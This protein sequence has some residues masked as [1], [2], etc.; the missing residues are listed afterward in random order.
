[1]DHPQPAF[2]L[3]KSLSGDNPVGES[4]LVDWWV[5]SESAEK[6]DN[7]TSH[8]EIWQSMELPDALSEITNEH[9]IGVFHGEE[10]NLNAIAIGLGLENIVFDPESFAG[11]IYEIDLVDATVILF[12]NG[13]RISIGEKENT[14][15][16]SLQETEERLD[17]IGLKEGST[18]TTEDIEAKQVETLLEPESSS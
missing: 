17:Q 10:L 18:P 12:H 16:Q 8:S 13:L 5:H 9:F 2:D 1:M 3:L 4:L 7:I 14:A 11:L 15:I 6:G